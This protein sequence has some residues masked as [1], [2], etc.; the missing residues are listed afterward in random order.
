MTDSGKAPSAIETPPPRKAEFSPRTLVAVIDD[1]SA[2]HWAVD[3]VRTMSSTEPY[4]IDPAH[5]VAQ[6]RAREAQEGPL[7]SAYR[8]VGSLLSDQTGLQGKYVEEARHNH[9]LVV[10][11]APDDKTA[12]ALWAVL[13][14][15]GAHD[16]TY[17]GGATIRELV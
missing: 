13:K 2:A 6:D 8:L 14:R 10:A 11:E 4:A 7:E 5:V 12:D 3:Q 16:G 9:W 1:P 17:F 15:S